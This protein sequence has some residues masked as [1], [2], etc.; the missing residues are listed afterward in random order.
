[1]N[2]GFD[3]YKEF[4]DLLSE[5]NYQNLEFSYIGNVPS[6]V[7]FVNTTVIEPLSGIALANEIKK[8]NIYL[9]ASINEPS[10]NHHIEVHNVDCRFY[11]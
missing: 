11:I 8:N 9:T 2:K 4:D 3:I 1:M 7:N 5:S 6:E 10:G